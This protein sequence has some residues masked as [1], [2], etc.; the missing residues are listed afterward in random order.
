[1]TPQGVGDVTDVNA[2]VD[3]KVQL[4]RIEESLKPLSALVPSVADV[5]ETSKEALT[6]AQQVKDSLT[7]MVIEHNRTKTIAEEALR[8][9]DA[10]LQVQKAQAEGRTWARRIFY[11][12]IIT[13]STGGLIAALW[14]GF[15]LATMQ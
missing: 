14:A 13:S 7:S 5:K 8:K 2:L 12:V 3:L 15:K 1:M 10:A 4:A 6:C 9:A 11:A